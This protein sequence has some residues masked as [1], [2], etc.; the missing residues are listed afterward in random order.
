MSVLPFFSVNRATV[1]NYKKTE[2]GAAIRVCS[3]EPER[4]M[5]ANGFNDSKIGLI[6]PLHITLGHIKTFLAAV[7]YES[8][9]FKYLLEFSLWYLRQESKV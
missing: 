3:W 8:V 6:S 1:Y 5:G 9:A 7:N 2:L 4:H